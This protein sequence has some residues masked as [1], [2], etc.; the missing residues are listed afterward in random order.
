MVTNFAKQNSIISQYISELRDINIQTDRLRFRE[1]LERLSILMAYEVSKTLEYEITKVETPLGEAEVN[2]LKSEVVLASI[3]R[4]GLPLHNGFLKV[5]DK[6]ENAFVSAYRKHHK[7]GSFEIKLEYV[8]CPSL[9][10]KTLIIVDPMLATGASLAT[11]IDNLKEYGRPT[12]IHIVTI[13]ASEQGVDHIRRLCPDAHIWTGAV[14][15]E[16][17]AKS[18]IVPGLGDAGDLAFG[19]KLQE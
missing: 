7:D 10:E 15:E 4:A 9:E 6:A 3:L 12:K 17:T 18:Y 14:D 13:I 5:F 8:T 16:L 2:T 1:N 19:S 11:T